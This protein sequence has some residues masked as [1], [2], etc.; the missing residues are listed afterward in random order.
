M[1]DKIKRSQVD[2]INRRNNAANSYKNRSFGKKKSVIDEY[3][4]DKIFYNANKHINEKQSN[5]DH[6]VPLD[7]QIRRY[8]SDLTPEQ[9][10]TMANDDANLANTNASLNKSKGALNNHEYIAKKYTEAGAAKIN[11]AS[12]TLFGKKI[13]KTNKKAVDCPDAVTSVNM[14]KEEVKAEAHIRTQA[15]KYKIENTVNEIKNSKV[16]SSKLDAVAPS[17]KKATAAGSEAAFVTATV[18]GLTNLVGVVKGEQD[19][20]QAVKNVG[21]DTV[22]SFGSAAGISVV[23]D[24]VVAVAKKAGAKDFAKLA[25]KNLPIM[26]LTMA[27]EIGGIVANY[28]D[29]NIS[30]EECSAQIVC[31]TAG[32]LA[33]NMA[34]AL[35]GP[36][37]AVVTSLVVGEITRAVTK[38][39]MERRLDKKRQAEFKHIINTALQ[40]LEQ[41]KQ[42]IDEY[43]KAKA[44]YMTAAFDGGFELVMQG[45][46]AVDEKAI[47]QGLNNILAVFNQK[48]AFQ[49]LEEFNTFFDDKDAVLT[50]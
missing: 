17:V 31:G 4:G 21:K 8:S 47:T 12:E 33:A 2:D 18:S 20:K 3:T 11:D 38:Y 26:Q 14:L 36:V 45:V 24:G 6:I 27:V 29:G 19:I 7:E 22:R 5:V 1:N 49:S 15:T 9:I 41:Q 32:V 37:A 10:R 35:G 34:F 13:F 39:Q 46:Y 25:G 16:I 40:S 48:C 43:N 50:L 28:L 30:G 23:Q 44:A 42:R